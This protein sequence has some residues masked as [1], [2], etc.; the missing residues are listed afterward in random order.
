MTIPRY[1]TGL[2]AG[3][4]RAPGTE[5]PQLR[6]HDIT[7][8]GDYLA[9]PDLAAAVDVALTLGM[10]LLLT[11]EPGS[12]KSA[13][14]D[15][16]AQELRFGHP[17]PAR[18]LRFPV[19]STTEA[20]D[21]FY[22]F[23]TVGR[24]HASQTAGADADARDFIRFQALGLALLRAKPL[25]FARDILKLDMER[26]DHPGEPLRSVVLID[27]IDKAPRDVPN[28]ILVE[29]ET[30]TFDIPELAAGRGQVHR[31]ALDP[32]S[33]EAQRRPLVIFTSNREQTLPEPFLR[34]CVFHHLSFPRFRAGDG[35]EITI[36]RI[37]ARRLGKRYAG[38]NVGQR[39]V[40]RAIDF[41]AYLREPEQERRIGRC[42]T[43]AELLNWLDWLLPPVGADGSPG[44]PED[45]HALAALDALW[46]QGAEDPAKAAPS[47]AD[48]ARRL[49]CIGTE[50]LLLKRPRD[51]NAVPAETLLGDW[52][53]DPKRRSTD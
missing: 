36:E 32:D 20:R 46:Q 44:G 16:V 37:V 52:A 23:D 40:Q 17:R 31:V 9:A 11:G 10:P 25:A 51:G 27:E 1:Y 8:P 47:A 33:D 42:P 12:G 43:L 30:M 35:R 13:L 24:F 3:A 2:G 49:L 4:G 48:G 39:R 41:F 45:W 22:T 19:K 53:T 21:L 29:L 18:D 6:V 15:S 50:S 38:D 7:D 34:R 5:L 26:L 14:A 28:D